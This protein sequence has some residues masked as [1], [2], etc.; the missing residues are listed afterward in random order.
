LVIVVLLVVALIPFPSLI[1]PDWKITVMDVAHKPVKGS[2]VR[3][4]YQNYSIESQGHE[5]DAITDEFGRVSFPARKIY[6]SLFARISGVLRAATG[7]VHAS[8]GPSAYV[9]AFGTEEEGSWEEDGH[10][11]FW[12]GSPTHL[13]ST[14]VLHP[15]QAPNRRR[16]TDPDEI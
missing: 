15:M 11:G 12:H 9:N 14:I 4:S 7:G 2:L 3:E 1:A 16:P 8:F 10:I 13:E 5:S 6:A